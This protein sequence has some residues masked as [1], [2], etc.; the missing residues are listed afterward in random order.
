MAIILKTKLKCSAEDYQRLY[1]QYSEQLYNGLLILT[2]DIELVCETAETQKL[3]LI[4]AEPIH[5]AD[6]TDREKILMAENRA[7]RDRLGHLLQSDFIR[8]FD[9]IELS[10][11]EYVRDIKNADKIVPYEH[12][13]AVP[14]E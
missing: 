2:P 1:S 10:T 11:G 13:V 12:I 6:V 4:E 9:E 5:E 7:L 3:E 8:S 14:I